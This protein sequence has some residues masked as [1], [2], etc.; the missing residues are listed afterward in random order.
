MQDQ[1]IFQSSGTL[2]IAVF[3]MPLPVNVCVVVHFA[4]GCV[5]GGVYIEGAYVSVGTG[6]SIGVSV[7][8]TAAVGVASVCWLVFFVEMLLP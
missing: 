8:T 3:L 6:V 1:R 2:K 7:A 4:G 5:G